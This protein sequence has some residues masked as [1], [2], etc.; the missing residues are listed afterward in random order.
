MKMTKDPKIKFNI[1]GK[2]SRFLID[3]LNHLM[4]PFAIFRLDE[5]EYH[6]QDGTHSCCEIEY[7]TSFKIGRKTYTRKDLIF[8]SNI[9]N[10]NTKNIYS[11]KIYKENFLFSKP[12]STGFIIKDEAILCTSLYVRSFLK[13]DETGILYFDDVSTL[14][15]DSILSRSKRNIY[16]QLNLAINAILKLI[17]N[18]NEQ[19][20]LI[21]KIN[22]FRG[23]R[24]KGYHPNVE[25]SNRMWVNFPID[26][27]ERMIVT[28][29]ELKLLSLLLRKNRKGISTLIKNIDKFDKDYYK[30]AFK[31]Y[32]LGY[33]LN[34]F[35]CESIR[36]ANTN[37][38][39]DISDFMRIFLKFTKKTNQSSKLF[40]E[41]VLK[42]ES[43][44][45]DINIFKNI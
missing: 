28:G 34:P 38:D 7:G 9:V 40:E 19:I 18:D 43:I 25:N 12:H 41:A 2:K 44:K 24:Y 16:N 27:E 17:P 29:K 36:V 8:D 35:I 45:N 42:V 14:K 10:E 5:Y 21:H 33:S 11:R 26:Y 37:F 6:K 3:Y 32:V 13:S 39:K 1:N 30:G 4:N 31:D 20:E 23:L 22:A 15:T